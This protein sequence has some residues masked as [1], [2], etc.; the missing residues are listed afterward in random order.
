MSS[1]EIHQERRETMSKFTSFVRRAPKRF[2]ALVAI[3]AAAI[4]IPVAVNAY[5]PERATFTYENPAP[6]VTFNSITNNPKVGDERN[7]VR[8]KEDSTTTTYGKDVTLQPGKTYQVEVYYHNNAASNLNAS[9]VGIA[10]DVSLRMQMP[11]SI[12]AGA[13]DTVDGFINSSN[14][15]PTSVWDSANLKN[16]STGA[17]ALRYVAGSAK[18]T[19]N[20]AVNGATLPDAFLTTGTPLGYDA[21]N[22]T[23]PGCNQYAGYVT[24]KFTVVQPNFTVEKTVSV[25][26]GKTYVKSGATTPG[27]TVIYK[28]GYT[29]TGSTQQDNVTLSDKL[30]AGVTYVQGSSLIANSK[31]SGK[32]E[33]TSDGI[34]TTGLNI[35]SYAP[36][37]GNAFFKFS[38]KA[39]AADTLKCGVNTFTNTARATTS[40]GYKESSADITITK[41]CVP[42]TPPPV[43]PP[44]TPPELPRTGMS[45]NIVAVIGLGAIV[46]SVAYYIAS[47]RA[48]NQ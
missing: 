34:T 29:N 47:R 28:V 7:F 11:A 4:I 26:G 40:G 5:G 15:N 48:L 41:E 3:V 18:V 38:A 45:E 9:G 30:P 21:L 2:S 25:D 10:K 19:S 35:G 22:G 13:S 31:T 36:N 37:G 1:C 46:A 27:S 43:T 17:V 6:Y 39:P 42:G 8:V 33:A 32:Y 12:A 23:L 16:G 44:V 14:A 20:G 24:Y